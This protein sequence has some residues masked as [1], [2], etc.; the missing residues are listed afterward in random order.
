MFDSPLKLAYSRLVSFFSTNKK[1]I[2][3]L[4]LCHSC[5]CTRTK[6][7]TCFLNMTEKLSFKMDILMRQD[8]MEGEWKWDKIAGFVRDKKRQMMAFT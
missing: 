4:S 5:I 3:A 2:P 6:C 1:E 7:S 8:V